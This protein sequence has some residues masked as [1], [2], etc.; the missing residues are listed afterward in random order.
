[1]AKHHESPWN[2]LTCCCA[3]NNKAGCFCTVLKN[4]LFEFHLNSRALLEFNKVAQRINSYWLRVH[5]P[6]C[7]EQAHTFWI[8]YRS[9]FILERWTHPVLYGFISDSSKCKMHGR[10]VCSKH[11]NSQPYLMRVGWGSRKA[12]DCMERGNG[13][14]AGYVYTRLNAH[15]VCYTI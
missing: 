4:C 15:K 10:H 1:M 12:N 2:G 6:P 3:Q 8:V 5:R 14:T 13:N 11:K 9:L 7:K